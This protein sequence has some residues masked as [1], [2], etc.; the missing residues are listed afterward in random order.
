[1]NAKRTPATEQYDAIVDFEKTVETVPTSAY[2]LVKFTYD[3]GPELCAPA[4]AEPLFHDLRDP[5][6]EPRLCPGSDFW[7]SK[8]ATDVVVTGSAWHRGGVAGTTCRVKLEVGQHSKSI[9]VFGKRVVTMGSAGIPVFGEPEPFTEMPVINA[10]AYGGWDARVPMPHSDA[11]V[12]VMARQFDHPGVYPRN[13]FGKGYVVVPEM[14]DNEVELPNLEDPQDL[15][16]PERFFV[17]DAR[18]WYRQP[19]PWCLDWSA[20]IMFHRYVWLGGDAWFPAP[21]D[22]LLPE[23]NRGMLPPSYREAAAALDMPLSAPLPFLQEASLGMVVFN[24]R[25]GTRIGLSGMH[26][27]VETFSFVVPAPPQIVFSLG[28]AWEPATPR[29]HSVLLLPGRKKL[30]IVYGATYAPLSRKYVPGVHA[31]IPL[32]M[33]VDRDPPILYEPP[34]TIGEAHRAA[35]SRG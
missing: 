21:D 4:P 30:Q 33:R 8:A 31:R 5:T 26:P 20:P 27:E 17:H 6:I 2:G 19:L 23:V 11:F 9:I 35:Q 34:P 16:T 18:L 14:P 12:D 24:L 29:I 7:P 10:N 1:M 13:P 15:L 28:D 3:I 22:A 32:A 25:E